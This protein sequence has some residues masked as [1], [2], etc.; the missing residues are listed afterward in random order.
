F[1]SG[2]TNSMRG[3]AY[4]SHLTD[5]IVADVGGTTTDFGN[6]QGGFPRQANSVVHIGGVRTLFRMPDLVSIGLGGGSLVNPKGDQI[7]PRS[8]GFRLTEESL[9][10]GGQTLTTTD[11]AVAAGVLNIG[12]PSLVK[13]LPKEL[14]R[15]T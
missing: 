14:I 8:V 13:H 7:G 4:L 15:N 2:P 10:F 5:A 1:A 11:I 12:D 3:A 6:L 9:V